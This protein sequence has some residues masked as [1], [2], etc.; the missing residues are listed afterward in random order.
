[1]SIGEH[2][3]FWTAKAGYY[4]AMIVL[5]II[6]IGFVEWLVGFAIIAMVAVVYPERRLFQLAHTVEATAFPTPN[7]NTNKIESEWRPFIKF[8]RLPEFCY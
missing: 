8:K 1:M 4:F 3:A 7:E 6:K 5:P 2:I